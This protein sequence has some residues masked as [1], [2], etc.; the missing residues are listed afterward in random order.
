MAWPWTNERMPQFEALQTDDY[1][2]ARNAEQAGDWD[3]A[4]KYWLAVIAREPGVYDAT[5]YAGH[6]LQRAGERDKAAEIFRAA[7]DR[8]PEAPWPI[9]YLADVLISL[10]RWEDALVALAQARAQFPNHFEA[11][12]WCV[13]PL[14]CLSRPREALDLLDEAEALF[15]DAESLSTL[16]RRVASR[17]ED[18]TEALAIWRKS[19][20]KNT[21]DIAA[22]DLR[23]TLDLFMALLNAN[24]ECDDV[25]DLIDELCKERVDEY[26]EIPGLFQ[27]FHESANARGTHPGRHERFLRWLKT[28]ASSHPV[29]DSLNGA[30]LLLTAHGAALTLVQF[31]AITDRVLLEFAQSHWSIRT[32]ANSIPTS[33]VVAYI[34]RYVEHGLP[35]RSCFMDRIPSQHELEIGNC[36]PHSCD[37]PGG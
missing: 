31:I 6:A 12:T 19:R 27:K 14:L 15:P 22:D 16:R 37:R 1:A 34:G 8:F 25:S 10:R 32:F 7:A 30:I 21:Q 4:A 13:E 11:F 29:P 2:A 17:C 18:A 5:I 24:V 33:Y 23:T 36:S 26:S 28:W 20:G 35:T 3:A 9:C